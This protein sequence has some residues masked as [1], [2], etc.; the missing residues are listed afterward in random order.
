MTLLNKLKYAGL[1]LINH[2][3]STRLT[4]YKN[5]VIVNNISMYNSSW[6]NEKTIEVPII[7]HEYDKLGINKFTKEQI[8]VLEIGN[9]MQHYDKSYK[10]DI[11]D[12]Y[13]KG[14]RVKNVDFLDWHTKNKYDYVFSISTFEHIGY[15][16]G[17]KKDP[18]QAL[19]ALRK[20]LWLLKPEGKAYI[21]V[22]VGFNKN[23]DEKIRAGIKDWR[24]M[25]YKRIKNIPNKW[26]PCTLSETCGIEYGAPF[27]NA[28]AIFILIHEPRLYNLKVNEN[29]LTVMVYSIEELKKACEGDEYKNTLPIV[30]SLINKILPHAEKELNQTYDIIESD[31]NEY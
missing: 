20:V 4:D 11:V 9:V 2:V 8:N 7:Q 18:K 25:C 26:T 16:Y 12:K 14:P 21:T 28:N 10:H 31:K 27:P 22:P 3:I 23:L 30:K 5:T 1:C 6:N 15:D 13:E 24:V 19:N 29:E 17:E